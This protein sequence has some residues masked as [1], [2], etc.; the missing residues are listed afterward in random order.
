MKKDFC[1]IM[2]AWNRDKAYCS[3]HSPSLSCSGKSYS[4][5]LSAAAEL[6]AVFGMLCTEYF[7]Y[8]SKSY[9]QF[10]SCGRVETVVGIEEW[11]FL[12]PPCGWLKGR[13]GRKAAAITV[14]PCSY[15][16]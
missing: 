3:A 6:A 16:G 12:L 15:S 2:A 9:C 7:D 10:S 1:R 11:T 4:L 5:S 13:E 14:S 8:S